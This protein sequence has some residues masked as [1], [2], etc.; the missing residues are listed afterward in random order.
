LFLILFNILD[1]FYFVDN[2]YIYLNGFTFDVFLNLFKLDL[3]SIINGSYYIFILT[4]YL[5]SKS[6]HNPTLLISISFILPISLLIQPDY[7][8]DL[9]LILL[10]YLYNLYL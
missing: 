5:T 2:D 3:L 8:Y 4:R 6:L 9:Y 7:L 10:Y 1:Y